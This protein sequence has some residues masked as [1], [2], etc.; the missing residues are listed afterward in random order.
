MKIYQNF[1]TMA[2]GRE[3][4][5]PT[6]KMV[7]PHDSHTH[8]HSNHLHCNPMLYST[9]VTLSLSLSLSSPPPPF[10]CRIYHH[11]RSSL[12]MLPQELEDESEEDEQSLEW[13]IICSQKV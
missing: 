12:P 10:V 11:S 6:G 5:L 4:T 7:N 8:I 3:A 2:L 1:S 13:H 9:L